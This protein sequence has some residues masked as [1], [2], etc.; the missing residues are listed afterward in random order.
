MGV[1]LRRNKEKLN[2]VS[3]QLDDSHSPAKR[4]GEEV[5]YQGIKK[6]NILLLTD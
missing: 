1:M 4:E 2:M 3:V 5:G 6:P